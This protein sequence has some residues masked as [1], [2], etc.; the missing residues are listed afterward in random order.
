[1]HPINQARDGEGAWELLMTKFRHEYPEKHKQCLRMDSD[2]F[3]VI[4]D[5]VRPGIT[6]KDTRLRSAIPAVQRLCV[7]LFYLSSGDSIRTVA[8]FFRMGESTVRSIIYDTCQVIWETMQ[9]VYLQTPHSPEEWKAV[10]SEFGRVWNFPHCIGA[11][12]GKH[13]AVQAP[14]KS[15]SEFYN[16]KKHFSIVLMATCDAHYR[17][18]YVDVGTPGRWSD[19]GT[20][21]HS[22][23][24]E[25]LTTNQLSLPVPETLP[26]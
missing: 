5:K 8:L 20:F 17:F 18:T 21:D 2:M 19:G 1:M 14:S 12:D 13:C 23:L 9:P 4:L 25:Q 26:G 6:K 7:T 10:A 11:I 22:S 16:Y 24:N 3:D 15:G